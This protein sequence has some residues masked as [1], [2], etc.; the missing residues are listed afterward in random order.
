MI[1]CPSLQI[2]DQLPAPIVTSG[3]DLLKMEGLILCILGRIVLL[4]HIRDFVD[5]LYIF[6][7]DL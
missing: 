4:L 2:S 5:T 3:R 7:F 1:L 6:S